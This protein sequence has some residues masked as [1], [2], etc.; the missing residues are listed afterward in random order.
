MR[1]GKKKITEKKKQKKRREKNF[2][3]KETIFISKRV[4]AVEERDV[5]NKGG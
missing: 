1:R 4:C 5:E 2:K 3:N